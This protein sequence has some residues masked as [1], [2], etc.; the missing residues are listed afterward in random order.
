MKEL[1]A[2]P[3]GVVLWDIDGTLI[4]TKRENFASPHKRLLQRLGFESNSSTQEFSGATDY[5]VLVGLL[6]KSLRDLSTKK[7]K[8]IFKELDTESADLDQ[9]T[10]YEVLPGVNQFVRSLSPSLWQQGILTG[11]TKNRMN[12]KLN[13]AM[14]SKLFDDSLMFNCEFGEMRSDILRRANWALKTNQ[15][16]NV[17]IIGDTPRDI[18]AAK[19]FNLPAV[20]VATGNFSI[21]QLEKYEPDLLIGSLE[22]EKEALVDF[23][24]KLSSEQI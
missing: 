13:N 1:Q 14:I 6:G 8:E 5:E 18:V 22:N 19:E 12:A 23:L 16:S 15:F 24:L 21:Q 2:K 10:V 7:L 20:A 3:P 4:R 17:C 11:N 9:I